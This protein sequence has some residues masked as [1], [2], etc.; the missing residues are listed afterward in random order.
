MLYWRYKI[1]FTVVFA[2][3]CLGFAV[4]VFSLPLVISNRVW[5]LLVY[6]VFAFAAG[7]ILLL[8]RRMPLKG[9]ILTGLLLLYTTGMVI[10]LKVGIL[11]G[12]PAWLFCCTVFAGIFIGVRA[13]LIC[14]LVNATSLF[15]LGMLKLSG[16][17]GAAFPFFDSFWRMLA[18][19]VNYLLVSGVTAISVGVMVEGL[20]VARQKENELTA[21]LKQSNE[22]FL[23]LADA[24][25]EAILFVHKERCLQVNQTAVQL[26]KAPSS[27]YFSGIP[28]TELVDP[29]CHAGMAED[30]CSGEEA[31]REITA[32]RMDGSSFPV[33]VRSRPMVFEGLG[34]VFAV[35]ME[36]LTEQKRSEQVSKTLLAIANAVS[37]TRNLDDLFAQIHHL[38]GDVLDTSNFF[39]ALVDQREGTL[40]FSYF[41]DEMEKEMPKPTRL[42]AKGSLTGL[43]AQKKAPMILDRYRLADLAAKKNMEGHLP[44]IWMGVPLIIRD[45]VIGVTAV[46]SYRDAALYTPRD[47][48]VFFS[49]SGQIALAI[50]RKRSEDALKASERKY[51]HLFDNSPAAIYEIDFMNKRITNANAAMCSYT[52]YTA[53]EFL[54]MHPMDLMAEESRDM[55]YLQLKEVV[56]DRPVSR[57][58]DY[59]LRKKN[60]ERLSVILNAEFVYDNDQIRTARVVVHDITERKKI[61]E[62]MARSE[63]MISIGGLAAGMAHEINNPLAGMIQNAQV[64]KNRLSKNMPANDS[65]AAEAGVSMASIAAFMEKRGIFR[66]LDHITDAGQRAA[67]IVSNMLSF[68]GRNSGFKKRHE[69]ESLLEETIALAWNDYEL[70]KKCD[71]RQVG[72]VRDY[73]SVPEVLCQGSK[74]QQVFFNLIRNAVEAMVSD[75]DDRDRPLLVCRIGQEEGFVRVDIEDN[76]PGMDDQTRKR[77]FEPFFTTKG[78]DRGTGLGLAISYFIVVEDHGGEMD[79]VSSPGNGSKFKILLPVC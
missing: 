29:E 37:L 54:S 33:S 6:D 56:A 41:V 26:F 23:S 22:R 11:S 2:S 9:K 8:S 58:Y 15:F 16:V 49:V 7:L 13:V 75:P 42:D 50:D 28:L 47:L 46:Q 78:V 19:G 60:G 25:M 38:L 14:L 51:R 44:L 67:Q 55:F 21:S 20:L 31:S 79:V 32:R 17:W 35:T 53:Q 68:A 76:G 72:I 36:D 30:I 3:L 40:S 66:Q 5:G 77:V 65:A 61:E 12:G 27:D 45:E 48:D 69:V 71:I 34:R 70:K 43:V 4:F 73:A 10:C 39:I 74:I 24:A 64:I 62:M 52:G 18:A 59:M 57:A 1:H 63:K